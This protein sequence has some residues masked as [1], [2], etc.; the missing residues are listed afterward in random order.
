VPGR[1]PAGAPKS[2][3]G[4]SPPAARW[5]SSG[6]LDLEF[7]GALRGREFASA[8][9]A[10]QD[11][12]DLGMRE[13]LSPHPF[14]D[15]VSMPP[16]IRR[17]WSRGNVVRLLAHLT[18]PDGQ[19]RPSGPLADAEDPV[20][21]RAALLEL[22]KRLGADADSDT[23]G[24]DDVTVDWRAA[25]GKQRRSDLVSVVV[26][27][28][29]AGPTL[30]AT[31]GV[32]DRAGEVEADVEVIVV[33]TGSAAHV[34]LGLHAAMRVRPGV[35]L[36]QLVGATD[37]ASSAANAGVDR[38]TGEVVVLL[39]PGVVLRR[40]A[41]GP[42]LA[43][44]DDP[45]VAGVQP[46]VLRADDTIDSAGL[47]VTSSGEAPR[48]V[49]T[50][51][52]KEDARRVGGE[53]LAAISDEVM[54]LRAQDIIS[55][56][57][58]ESSRPR[59][60]AAVDLCARLLPRRPAGF[61]LAPTALATVVSRTEP[62]TAPSLSPHHGLPADPGLYD[63]IGFVGGPGGARGHGPESYVSGRR[64]SGEGLRWSI[65]LPSAPGRSGDLWGDTHFADALAAAL[66]ALGQDVVTSRRDAHGVGPTHLDD[67]SLA[68]RGLYPIAPAPGKVNV[69]WV[70]SHPD[71]VTPEELD[72][73][74]LVFAASH[75][76]STLMSDRCGREVTPLLQASEF[77]RPAAGE[78][79]RS[80]PSLVFVGNAGGSRERPLVHTAVEAGV[81][82]AVY[83]R[84]WEDLP[85]G[86]WRGEYID[87]DLLP[88][89]Y[90]RH[91]IVLADHWPDM[92][93]HGFVANRV[94]DA[95]AS[96]ARVVCDDVVGVHEVFDP[97]D[98]V[99]VRTPDDV[100]AAVAELSRPALASPGH[101][102]SLT[103]HD[104][105]ATLLEGVRDLARQSA[106]RR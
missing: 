50:G 18:G 52:P 86:I 81:P 77:D 9:A 61:R 35:D 54:V 14:L 26:V 4:L 62:G 72:G 7:Y 43:A 25:A 47:V 12:V 20:S 42:L 89:L 40:G 80:D 85:A 17:A 59:H 73:Y 30:R 21:T 104:R 84:G 38:S 102:T 69:L 68:L 103:F 6:L 99:V 106:D 93:R 11:F 8:D 88:D 97:S 96:G 32:L 94:F 48:R 33:N 45:E 16:D 70:I 39:E 13:R 44:I 79:D 57:G 10:A 36:V 5:L 3:P 51:H 63:R 66:G 71:D 65:K 29:G 67:V 56:A 19:A 101:A 23:H 41:L 28:T 90:H 15:F 100:A 75:P 98:V 74:D 37:A 78:G 92:A 83:G 91:G 82:L 58:L 22:A 105:A 24:P 46:V 2:E 76:W 34:A 27:A 95:V 31:D 87:N 64:D 60:D 53:R 1:A 55:V 49:L